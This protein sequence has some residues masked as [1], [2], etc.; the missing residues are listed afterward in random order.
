MKTLTIKIKKNTPMKAFRILTLVTLM[1]NAAAS[2]HAQNNDVEAN[3]PHPASA[4]VWQNVEK[5]SLGWGSTDVRY[6][7]GDVPRLEKDIVLNAWR[8]ERVSAQ[9]VL[10]T[11]KNIDRLTLEMSDLKNGSNVIPSQDIRKYFVRYVLTDSYLAKNG[12]SQHG[13]HLTEAFD[14]FLVADRLQPAG[15]MRVEARTVRPLWIDIRVPQDAAPGRYKGMMTVRTDGEELALPL[16]LVVSNR[17]LPLPSQWKFHLDLWQNPYSVAD[18]YGVPLWSKEHFDLMRPIMTELANAG[19]KVI[20]CSVIRHP[21]NSQTHVPFESMIGKTRRLDGSWSYNYKVFDKWVEFMMDCGITEQI[22]CYTILPWHSTFEYFDEQ[23]NFSREV[24]LDPQS[25]EYEEYLLPFLSDF[26]R[27]LKQKGWFGKT[28]IAMDERPKAQLE[29]AYKVLYKADK[30]Y[31]VEGAVNYFAPEMAER[32]YDVSFEYAH[33]ALKKD[34]LDSHLGRGGKVTFYT[35]C[36]PVRPNTFTFSPPAESAYLGWHAAAMGYSGYLRWAYNS[37]VANQLTD[38]R[39]RTWPAGDCF[40]VYPG[41]SSIRMERLIEGIQAYEKIQILRSELK[42]KKLEALENE[43]KRFA[44]VNME[45]S[46]NAADEVN[47][48]RQVLLRLE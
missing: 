27:H 29:A 22:D 32:M 17:T 38:S 47:H 14:S 35:C 24:R 31:R 5:A 19:Q 30:D 4:E 13:A 12:E 8:G 48:A 2:L 16:T 26:A 34:L 3:D 28:C 20:T 15:E 33:P 42:G 1:T 41:G 21:W 23:T 46:V 45:E 43:L 39:F 36:G 37:W 40:L 10:V 7:K 9:A 6:G 25:A 44:P 11:P 18:F